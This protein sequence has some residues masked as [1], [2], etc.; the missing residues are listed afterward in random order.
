LIKLRHDKGQRG[1][2]LC[3]EVLVHPEVCVQEFYVRVVFRHGAQCTEVCG[4]SQVEYILT[5]E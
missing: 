4:A 1:G 2:V 3:G 5:G